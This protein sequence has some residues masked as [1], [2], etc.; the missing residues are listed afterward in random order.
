MESDSK[1]LTV[2][3]LFLRHNFYHLGFTGFFVNYISTVNL[4][5]FTVKIKILYVSGWRDMVCLCVCA[6][7]TICDHL[8]SFPNTK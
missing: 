6:Q 3:I 7:Y 1:I 4:H 8:S 5:F 2:A